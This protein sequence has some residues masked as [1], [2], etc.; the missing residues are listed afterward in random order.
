MNTSENPKMGAYTFKCFTHEQVKEIN[1]EIKT[2]E[3]KK[4]DPAKA[5]RNVSKI[6]EF[7]IVPC[8]PLMEILHPWL[9]QCQVV[10]RDIYGY[11]IDWQFH[12]DFMNYNVYG[13]NGEYDWHIDG[14]G[15]DTLS[16]IKLTCLLNLSE[17]TYEGGEFHTINDSGGKH[18]FAPGMGLI[19]N[20]LIAHQVTPVTK[21][22]RI[23]LT[24]WAQGPAWR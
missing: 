7:S 21:G 4:Q 8:E 3:S 1:K 5:A 23:T 12:L 24:Y 13:E 15:G 9:Y 2:Q 11:N 6:G 14:T 17:E 10:N 22:E 20:S 16:D 19:L 18:D